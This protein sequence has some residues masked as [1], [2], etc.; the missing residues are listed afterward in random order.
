MLSLPIIFGNGE[1]TRDFVYVEDV[2]DSVLSAIEQNALQHSVFNIGTGVATSIRTLAEMLGKI[3]SV[4]NHPEFTYAIPSPGILQSR[5]NIARAQSLDWKPHVPLD[6]GLTKL[7][8]WTAQTYSFASKK[9]R[10]M[11]DVLISQEVV[12]IH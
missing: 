2:A 12:K 5:A 4:S 8:Q 7:V 10:I 6:E 1:Q 11:Q 9:N 3:T